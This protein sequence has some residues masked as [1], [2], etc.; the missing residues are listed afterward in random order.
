MASV[1]PTKA[2]LSKSSSHNAQLQKAGYTL[3]VETRVLAHIQ[4]VSAKT[5]RRVSTVHFSQMI[6][7]STVV[8]QPIRQYPSMILIIPIFLIILI[9]PSSMVGRK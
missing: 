2:S 9:T 6:C 4:F 7:V 8:S 5:I 1:S 3:I